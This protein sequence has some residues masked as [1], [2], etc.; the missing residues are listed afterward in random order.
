MKKI[1]FLWG[2]ILCLITVGCTPNQPKADTPQIKINKQVETFLNQLDDLESLTAQRDI[3]LVP[4]SDYTNPKI[5]KTISELS[6]KQPQSTE[7]AAEQQEKILATMLSFYYTKDKQKE[8]GDIHQEALDLQNEVKSQSGEHKTKV[9]QAVNDFVKLTEADMKSFNDAL[10]FINDV[11]PK[12]QTKFSFIG[13]A[14]AASTDN[15]DCKEISRTQIS[16]TTILIRY[17][18]VCKV[19]IK[20]VQN[21]MQAQQLATRSK[22]ALKELQNLKAIADKQYPRDRSVPT[23]YAPNPNMGKVE[24]GTRGSR[25]VTDYLGNKVKLKGKKY[26]NK[27]KEIEVNG[28]KFT[29][30]YNKEFPDFTRH[31]TYETKLQQ[32]DWFQSDPT[33]FNKL[34]KELYTKM[35]NTPSVK[36]KI[37]DTFLSVLQHGNGSG[38]GKAKIERFLKE[39]PNVEQMGLT[40]VD[41]LRLTNGQGVTPE[42]WNI[43]NKDP[44]LKKQLLQSNVDWIKK[45]ETPIGYV[46]NHNE[47]PGRMQLVGQQVHDLIPHTGGRTIWG[48]AKYYR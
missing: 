14:E 9:Q 21:Q 42:T 23:K 40:T 36:K 22:I 34:N 41:R 33:Q 48:G 17:R 32:K 24:A 30:K 4:N 43:I 37:D 47:T 13:V 18:C 19:K 38:N 27:E 7:E 11:D 5:A 8:L 26:W 15:C 28:Q 6:K 39:T 20:L 3:L 16:P 12:L 44:N 2:F 45:G 29:V 46:W 31:T 10:N 25:Y 1:I 35:S